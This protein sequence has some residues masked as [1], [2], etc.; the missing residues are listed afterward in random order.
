MISSREFGAEVAQLVDG[1][2]KLTQLPRVSRIN[3]G[4][5]P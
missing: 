5:R 3:R 4:E 1:V 2:T